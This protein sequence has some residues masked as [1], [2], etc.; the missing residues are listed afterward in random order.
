MR[1]LRESQLGFASALLDPRVVAP[2]DVCCHTSGIVTRRFNVYRNNVVVSL[3]EALEATFPVVSR[4]VG[5]EFF[6]AMAREFVLAAPPR[7]PILSRYGST[8]PE[9]LRNFGPVADLPYLADVARLEWLQLRAYHAADAPSLDASDFADLDPGRIAEMVV[10]LLP[11]ARLFT[12]PFACVSIW[13]TNTHD[14][15][16]KPV[17]NLHQG[18]DALVLRPG[19]ETIVLPLPGGAYRFINEL[20][21]GKSLGECYAVASGIAPAFDLQFALAALIDCGAITSFGFECIDPQ[22]IHREH[23]E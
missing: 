1:D 13:R 15:V 12:S 2:A 22:P 17:E 5:D 16:V 6:A 23:R 10:Q 4:L 9:F 20:G 18:E 3:I 21:A 8:F 7:S 11:S 14:H 19:L